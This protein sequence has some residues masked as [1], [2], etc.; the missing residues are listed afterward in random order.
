MWFLLGFVGWCMTFYGVYQIGNL[1]IRGFYWMLS[2]EALIIIDA[3]AF[4][5]FSLIFASVIFFCINTRNVLKWRRNARTCNTETQF[6]ADNPQMTLT[7][8]KSSTGG[9][10]IE[11][12]HDTHAQADAYATNQHGK[13]QG[14]TEQELRQIVVQMAIEKLDKGIE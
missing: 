14:K 3:L 7:V 11:I 10:D 13:Y 4:G 5:H 8:W 6:F 2:A 1:N 12:G 9:I